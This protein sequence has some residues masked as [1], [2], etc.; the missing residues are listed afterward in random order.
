MISAGDFIA[1][2]MF[3]VAIMGIIIRECRS[4]GIAK[5]KAAADQSTALNVAN[6][7]SGKMEE[8]FK[9][10]RDLDERRQLHELACARVQER[11]ATIQ[12]QI[13]ATLDRNSRDIVHL[14]AQMAHVGSSG[15]NRVI[16]LKPEG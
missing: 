9:L 5:A 12:S 8:I 13:L 14:Q 4:N 3:I 1:G 11:T 2:A 15:A 7:L 16:E 6:T 10:Y